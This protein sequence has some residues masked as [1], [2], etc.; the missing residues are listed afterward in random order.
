M[1]MAILAQKG[2]VAID[3]Y[4]Y[5]RWYS[6]HRYYKN[7]KTIID[8]TI[9]KWGSSVMSDETV[10]L[11]GEE[12][13]AF[14]AATRAAVDLAIDGNMK[15]DARQNVMQAFHDKHRKTSKDKVYDAIPKPE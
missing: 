12:S 8:C 5:Y 4:G 11:H 6:A 9:H 2:F 3:M 7:R 10:I 14:R 13:D 15:Q 1:V